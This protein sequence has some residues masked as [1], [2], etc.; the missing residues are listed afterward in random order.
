MHGNRPQ[1]PI[2]ACHVLHLSSSA[3]EV[4]ALCMAP[5]KTPPVFALFRH[6][7]AYV[8]IGSPWSNWFSG[9]ATMATFPLAISLVVDPRWPL[10][11]RHESTCQVGPLKKR[12]RSQL[13]SLASSRLLSLRISLKEK[14]PIAERIQTQAP[15][16]TTRP[17]QLQEKEAHQS[18]GYFT[19]VNEDHSSP[20]VTPFFCR[21]CIGKMV[22][23][24]NDVHD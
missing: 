16:K 14:K 12:S 15:V 13:S 5:F 20:I 6:A 3:S 18:S 23:N 11:P 8:Q 24:H 7:L 10:G 21:K 22:M 9:L 19:W 17:Q 4:H 2:Q 1:F